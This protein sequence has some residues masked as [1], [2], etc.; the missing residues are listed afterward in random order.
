[1]PSA[2]WSSSSRPGS[3]CGAECPRRSSDERLEAALRA[4]MAYYRE[5][6]Q[7]G[8]DE[9]SLADLRERCAVLVSERAR[10]S[11]SA[12]TSWSPR[13]ASAPIRTPFRRSAV[14]ATAGCAWSPSRTGTARLPRVLERC[15][16]GGLLD[17]TVTR[18]GPARGS[19]TRRSSSAALELAG[20]EARRGA[21]RRGHARG[22]RRRRPGGGHP[23]AA[24]RSRRRRRRHLLAGGDRSASLRCPIP[25]TRASGGAPSRRCSTTSPGSSGVLPVGSPSADRRRSRLWRPTTAGSGVL[26]VLLALVQLLRLLRVALGP[27]DRQERHRDRGAL[28]DGAERLTYGQASIRNLLR[29]ID[30]FVIGEVMIVADGRKPAPRRQGGEDGGRPPRSASRTGGS[31]P[32]HSDGGDRGCGRVRAPRGPTAPGP[33]ARR[34]APSRE[35]PAE[36]P[37]MPEV[38]WGLGDS[39]WGLIGGPAPGGD[40]AAAA[41]PA[42]RPAHRRSGQ[43]ERR[44]R[45]WPRRRSSTSS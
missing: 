27:D 32:L 2:R 33:G 20:V 35:A 9:A 37:R 13:S 19:P 1:M 23:A 43:G 26:V 36:E 41:R 22:G 10:G 12:S 29:L 42:V 45:S 8:R 16:L 31:G 24:D 21:P 15:G 30:F 25:T 4:E 34:A 40:R 7:E 5:H 28:V 44:R 6:A 3:P 38:T 39:I 14:C 17:G 18:P 11:R